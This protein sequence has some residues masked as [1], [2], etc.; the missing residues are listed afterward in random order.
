M[1]SLPVS[2]PDPLEHAPYFGRYISQTTGQELFQVLRE[3]LDRTLALLASISEERSLHRY[4]PE[5][6]SIRQ[7]IGHL[8]DAERIFAYRALRFARNDKT[9][10]APFDENLY[11]AEANFDAIP[12]SDLAAEFDLVRCSS[13]RLFRQFRPSDWDRQGIAGG[14][15]MSVRAFAWTI[16]G[17]EIHHR[18]ILESRYLP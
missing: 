16:A 5:K 1:E 7:V 11:V 8:I 10:L 9:E 14:N 4:A 13:L 12:L 3:E 17:H 2:R 6:W 15:R 18:T